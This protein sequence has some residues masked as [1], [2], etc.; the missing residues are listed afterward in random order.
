MAPK[1]TFL[2][3]F[4]WF[5]PTSESQRVKP[6]LFERPSSF[7]ILTDHDSDHKGPWTF[8]RNLRG[9]GGGAECP[10]GTHWRSWGGAECPFGTHWRSWGLPASSRLVSWGL[11]VG[12]LGGPWGPRAVLERS[13]GSLGLSLGRPVGLPLLLGLPCGDVRVF[14]CRPGAHAPLRS[15]WGYFL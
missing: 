5:S 15:S 11:P 2:N 3:T 13:L 8:D 14:L 7:K 12:A 6:S 4:S 9:C 10:F 1:C